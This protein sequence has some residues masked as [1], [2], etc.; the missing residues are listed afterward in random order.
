MFYGKNVFCVG[1]AGFSQV[2]EKDP[3]TERNYYGL[4]A[5]FAGGTP[6]YFSPEQHWVRKELEHKT[7]DEMRPLKEKWQ[8]TPATSDLFQVALTVA[9][10]YERSKPPSTLEKQQGRLRACINRK[11][12][13]EV[14]AFTPQ[15]LEDWL[16]NDCG[17]RITR[18]NLGSASISVA[19][20]I[21]L[22]ETAALKSYAR[23]ELG[24]AYGSAVLLE[25][26]LLTRVA[27]PAHVMDARVGEM[28]TKSLSAEVKERFKSTGEALKAIG[29]DVDYDDGRIESLSSAAGFDCVPSTALEKPKYHTDEDV[30]TTLGGISRALVLHGDVPGALDAVSQWLG[31]AS[32]EAARKR[33]FAA[34]CNL[35]KY[36]GKDLKTM[37]LSREPPHGHWR[38]EMLVGEGVAAELAKTARF[39]DALEGLDLSSQMLRR[40]ALDPGGEGRAEG[41]AAALRHPV[42]MQK[43]KNPI[44]LSKQTFFVKIEK[45][46]SS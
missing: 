21:E 7:K 8:L 17:I 5:R 23:K 40:P 15:E 46:F 35:W 22:N 39:S 2:M 1:L 32:T 9:E 33:A 6:M 14:E 12:A 24:M 42:V 38:E 16:V 25:K 36:H 3:W 44:P 45:N 13:N 19:R 10:M 20:M 34:Y 43:T 29:A 41:E 30:S 31:V 37:E 4:A 27:L 11:P 26:A 18:G 28:L